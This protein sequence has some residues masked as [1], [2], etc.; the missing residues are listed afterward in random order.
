[1]KIG[2]IGLGIMGSRMSA[3]LL[4][5]NFELTIYN[6]TKQK[7]EELISQSANWA[8]NP[9]QLAQNSDA[10]ITML[11][12][13]NAVN[14]IAFGE[15]GFLNSMKENSIWINCSTVNPSYTK[16][17]FEKSKSNKIRFIDAP[18]AGS[19]IPAEQGK[20]TFLI[21]ADKKDFEEYNNI[22]EAMGEKTNFVGEVGKGSSMKMV[23]NLMLGVSMAAFAEAINLGESL[24]IE[25]DILLNTLFGGPVTPQFIAF[26][27]EKIQ[28]ENFDAE[29]PLQWMLKDLFLV[30]QTA[31]E[32]NVSSIITNSA[33]E[34]YLLAKQFGFGE[35][36][37]SAVVKLLN[38]NSKKEN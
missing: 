38:Q 8:E 35:E 29:F 22:F 21:G 17:I 1:M 5:K 6:R 9:K 26:K 12:E 13:P 7:A 3:N 15:N 37:F 11:S 4:K 25:K 33:K 23:I 31:Y 34:I 2:F 19:K 16:E 32:Q 10:V 36:D 20:L 28:N 18:V 30:S 14:E 27:K 24:G